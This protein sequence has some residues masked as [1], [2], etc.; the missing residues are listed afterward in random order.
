MSER[1]ILY[2][3]DCGAPY[4]PKI[5]NQRLCKFHLSPEDRHQVEMNTDWPP[6][7]RPGPDP[8]YLD[9]WGW[10]IRRRYG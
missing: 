4:V 6:A 3:A 5:E 8:T 10:P 1:I 9:A 7:H 2:C